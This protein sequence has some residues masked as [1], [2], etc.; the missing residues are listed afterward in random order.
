[1]GNL[2]CVAVTFSGPRLGLAGMGC[3]LLRRFCEHLPFENV[4]AAQT[5]GNE[6]PNL[7]SPLTRGALSESRHFIF[8]KEHELQWAGPRSVPGAVH[9]PSGR[10]R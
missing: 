7:T 10:K 2:E 9:S 1:M 3:G 5:L 4:T 6:S 8:G